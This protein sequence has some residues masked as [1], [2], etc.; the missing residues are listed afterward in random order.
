MDSERIL[1]VQLNGKWEHLDEAEEAIRSALSV[2][3]V[4]YAISLC[5][6]EEPDMSSTSAERRIYEKDKV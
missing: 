1:L 3:N 5:T 4:D 2:I 6:W